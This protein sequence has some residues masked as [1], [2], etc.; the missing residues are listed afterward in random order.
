VTDPLAQLIE[1]A[2]QGNALAQMELARLH[3][4]GQGVPLS[5]PTAEVWYRKAAEQ[6]FD[7]AQFHLGRLLASGE[8]AEASETSLAAAESWYSRAA[9]QGNAAAMMA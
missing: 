3:E 7:A 2:E 5:P 9:A 6:G 4:K 8:G 1:A